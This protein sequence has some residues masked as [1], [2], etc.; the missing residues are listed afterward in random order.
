MVST[1]RF[2]KTLSSYII[3]FECPLVVDNSN[4]DIAPIIR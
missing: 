4:E 2:R 3:K 1:F